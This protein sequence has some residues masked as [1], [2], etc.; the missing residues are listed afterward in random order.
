MKRRVLFVLIV[1]IL[2]VVPLISACAESAPQPGQVIKL[3]YSNFFP[4]THLN[5]ILAQQWCDEIKAQTKGAVEITHYPGGTL[6]PAPKVYDGVVTGISDIGMSALSYTM[7]RFPAS[8][9]IDLPHGYPSGWVATQMAN[10]FYKKFKPKE[11][12]DTQVLYFHAHGPGVLLTVKKPVSTLEDVKGLVIRSTGVG[13][14][15]AEALG[16]KGYAAA[17]GEAYELMSKGTIDGS[18]TPL[19]VLKGW[20]QAEV[21]KYVTNCYKM[22]YTT[23]FFVVMNKAKWNSLPG[24]IKDVFNKANEAWMEK[25]AKVWS[26]YDKA[27]LDYFL[28]FPERK[29]IELPENEMARWIAATKPLVDSYIS[30]KT[31]KGLPVADYEK[32]LLEQVKNWSGKAPSAKDCVDWVEKNLQPK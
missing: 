3:T 32:Y 2:M 7:G 1:I 8:E 25:H 16:A 6:T 10:D 11:L 24:N 27:A 23:T 13:A 18:Y 12:D 14:Q 5:S 4:P 21:V 15:I 29:V 20:K 17:Q 9:A 31:A 19:E 28:T 30:D 26:Y 22:G